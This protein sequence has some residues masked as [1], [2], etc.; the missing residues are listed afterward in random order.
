M[1]PGG[2][3]EAPVK[4]VPA[5]A[6]R[7]AYLVVFCWNV[8]CAL[9]FVLDPESYVAGFELSGV[10]GRV[11][12]QGLGVAFL[13]WNATYPAVI[14]SPRRFRSLSVVVV[15][16]QA[17]GLVGESW[18]MASL[19]AGHAA[20]V[21]SIQRFIVFDTVGLAIMLATL[22]WLTVSDSRARTR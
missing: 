12:V 20:L 7:L 8:V 13:M 16:Q 14:A 5:I 18:I 6:V 11:A 15:V 1:L 2:I 9:Q 3:G 19:P 21:A 4:R 22:I 10:E 17:I